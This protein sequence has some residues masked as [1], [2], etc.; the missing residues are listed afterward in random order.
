M[1]ELL[2]MKDSAGRIADKLTVILG[3]LGL[4]HDGAF[5][6]ITERQRGAVEELLATSEELRELLAHPSTGTGMVEKH[7]R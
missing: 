2:E 6:G 1:R 3:L 4:L 7:D 5:G